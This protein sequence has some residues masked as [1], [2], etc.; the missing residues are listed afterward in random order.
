MKLP[1]YKRNTIGSINSLGRALGI[2]PSHLV[3]LA[4]NVYK[5]YPVAWVEVKSDGRRKTFYD[6][7]DPIKDLQRSLIEVFFDHVEF[8]YYINGGIKGRSYRADC[9]LH[10]SA[11]TVINLDV[12]TF[13]ESVTTQEV[14]KL[15]HTFFGFSLEVANLLTRL[16]AYRGQLPRGAPTSSYLANLLFWDSEPKLHAALERRGI[17]YS[18]YVDDVSLSAKRMLKEHEIDWAIKGIHRMFRSKGVSPNREKYGVS[19]SRTAVCIHGINVNGAVPTISKN[20][21]RE[22]RAAAHNLAK[23]VRQ[24]GFD[25]SNY[26][27]VAY[28]DHVS[29]KLAWVRQFH[30]GSGLAMHQELT[31]ARR[32]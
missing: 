25:E 2:S 31:N 30:P 9:A 20:E 12:N 17:R 13:F 16:T 4:N 10:V 23:A 29:G 7:A 24:N 11:K 6:P 5:M 21:R 22:L 19:F 26:E 18:R 28:F 1:Y 14:K 8:P 15:W 27:L 32:C 3:E